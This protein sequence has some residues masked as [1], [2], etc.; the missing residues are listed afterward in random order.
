MTNFEKDS[1]MQLLEMLRDEI[2]CDNIRLME[3]AKEEL[4][5]ACNRLSVLVALTK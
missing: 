4:M 3:Q 1:L 5:D 2:E